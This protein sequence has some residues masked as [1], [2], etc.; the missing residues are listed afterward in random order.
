MDRSNCQR[1]FHMFSVQLRRA[2]SMQF[3]PETAIRATS[4]Q[5]LLLCL[6]ELISKLRILFASE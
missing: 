4:T 1:C 5:S 6:L 3:S 2:A